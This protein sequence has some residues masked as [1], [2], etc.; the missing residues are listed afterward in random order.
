LARSG[1]RREQILVDTS[2]WIAF[3]RGTEPHRKTLARLLS[4]GRVAI[5]GIV[6]AEIIQGV[7]S[8]KEEECLLAALNAVDSLE[9]T[10]GTWVSAGRLALEMR[11]K[12][13]TVPLTD[14]A[15]AALAMEHDVSVLTLDKH[16]NSIPG[17]ELYRSG[18]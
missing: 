4:E 6:K 11:R 14:I 7:K 5:T 2:V 16:F 15:L 3:L 13:T 8:T 17:V 12:G 1:A 18:E 10:D 9:I